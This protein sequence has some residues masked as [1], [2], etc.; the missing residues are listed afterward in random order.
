MVEYYKRSLRAPPNRRQKTGQLHPLRFMFSGIECRVLGTFL[1][2]PCWDDVFGADI[3]NFYSSHN[4]SVF[5]PKG[6]V[7]DTSLNFREGGGIP[8]ERPGQDW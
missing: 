3:E 5:K 4:Y 2:G 8:A 6:K 7:L 1:Q